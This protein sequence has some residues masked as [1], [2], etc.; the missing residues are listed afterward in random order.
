MDSFFSLKKQIKLDILS[1]ALELADYESEVMIFE[2]FGI[3]EAMFFQE[4]ATPLAGL[5]SASK[6]FLS[7][8]RLKRF[9][10]LR[11]KG[12]PLAY[13]FRQVP[14]MGHTYAIQ[15]G[16]LI[17]RP[18]TELLVE[19]LLE[20][21]QKEFAFM[22]EFVMIEFGFGSGVISLEVAQRYKQARIYA[23]DV[24]K[25]AYRLAQKN[26]ALMHVKNVSWICQDFFKDP[27]IFWGIISRSQP[28]LFVGNPPYVSAV[29]METLPVDVKAYEPKR[30]LYGGKDGLDIYR[31]LLRLLK[32]FRGVFIFEIGYNQKT[33]LEQ[34]AESMGYGY[35][36]FLSDYRQIPRI[37]VLKQNE[38]KGSAFGNYKV[39]RAVGQ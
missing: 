20:H 35:Y 29:D 22:K 19:V 39:T 2:A 24:S 18:E 32:P 9:V 33:A 8:R 31:K 13:I 16:V 37:I 25:K 15:K 38:S 4:L 34:L 6:I 12:M 21:I 17:P 27:E 7:L 5:F 10:A 1:V 28:F 23:W 36:E 30:A 3:P 26:A 14:F 11:Q